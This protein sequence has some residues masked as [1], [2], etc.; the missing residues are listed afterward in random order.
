M[1]FLVNHFHNN[2]KIKDSERVIK[3]I[4]F[5]LSDKGNPIKYFHPD[6]GKNITLYLVKLSSN[7]WRGNLFDFVIISN[8]QLISCR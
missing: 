1:T 2:N 3:L 5:L 6:G 4:L 8:N 7:N